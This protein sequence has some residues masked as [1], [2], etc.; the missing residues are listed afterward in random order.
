MALFLELYLGHL[1]GDFL[2]QPGRL[3]VAKRDGIPG[4]LLHTLVIG[5]ASLAVVAGTV[6]TDWGPVLFVT[7]LHLV[8]ERITI[9]TYLGTRTRGLFTFLLDQALH[10]LSI[11]F[12]VFATGRWST[13]ASAAV[14][15]IPVS[16]VGL[17]ELCGL[18]TVSLFGS[19]L[20]FETANAVLAESKGRILRL[21]AARL[22]GMAERGLAF[23]AAFI[24]PFLGAAPFLPR[25]VW[26]A[27]RRG[28]DRRR[29]IV[30]AAAGAVLCAAAYGCVIAVAYL[31][32]GSADS[33]RL[34]A[35]MLVASLGLASLF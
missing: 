29:D 34:G 1:L 21:D 20:V 10:V 4:L 15:G 16:V 17:A 26:A 23:A 13:G 35:A 11:A 14:F 18:V 5:G 25:L 3:V 31:V 30:E 12:I 24:N 8:I 9:V 22:Y 7:G 2:L 6:R 27:T 32:H 19:I 28:T 33:I